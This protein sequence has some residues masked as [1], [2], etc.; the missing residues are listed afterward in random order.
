[1]DYVFAT[2]SRWNSNVCKASLLASAKRS[3]MG[4]NKVMVQQKK[5][6][7]EIADCLSQGR[8]EKARIKAESLIHLQKLETA[9]DILE[10]LMELV[11]T[12]M[13]YINESKKCPPDLEVPIA[14]IIYASKRL[15][16]P[17]FKNALKQFAAKFGAGFTRSHADNDS[18]VVAHNLVQVLLISPPT[19]G[20]V[21]DLLGI[22]ATKHSVEWTPPR[23]LQGIDERSK[24][25]QPLSESIAAPKTEPV[26]VAL[27]PPEKP[28]QY[29][30]QGPVPLVSS[31]AS[32][33][34]P[35]ADAPKEDVRK[36]DLELPPA[37]P[38]PVNDPQYNELMERLRRLK[39]ND[40]SKPE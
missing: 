4:R 9:Y 27:P 16:I 26:V 5:I 25:A 35:K 23:K 3:Q 34:E 18:G 21:H 31:L 28:F 33:E 32:A 14:T 39:L 10:T 36:D 13:Q 24:H 8:E 12:R 38:S 30:E 37:P 6:E 17:E 22:I 1:M 7:T 20:E 40:D 19:E 29:N 11:Q 15:M 2:F